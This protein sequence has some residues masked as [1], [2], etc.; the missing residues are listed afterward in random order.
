MIVYLLVWLIIIYKYGEG[1]TTKQKLI[2][3]YYGKVIQYQNI[4]GYIKRFKI[5]I[6]KFLI[7]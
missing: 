3:W 6:Y 4:K 2:Y 7:K 1:P 5:M